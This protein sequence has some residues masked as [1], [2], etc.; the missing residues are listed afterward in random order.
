MDHQDSNNTSGTYEATMARKTTYRQPDRVHWERDAAFRDQP[1][2]QLHHQKGL[3]GIF[4]VRL[5]EAAGLERSYWSAL[6]IGPVKHLGLSTAHGPVSSYCTFGMDAE[7]HHN[8]PNE[9]QATT[10]SVEP[11]GKIP[12]N[13]SS[14]SSNNA[15][16]KMMDKALSHPVVVSPVMPQD[17]NPVWSDFHFELPLRKGSLRE[18]GMRIYLNVRVDENAHVAERILPGLPKGGDDRLIGKGRVDATSLCLGEK[19]LG[20]PQVGVLDAWVPIYYTANDHDERQHQTAA[21]AATVAA[22]ASKQDPL[23]K[24]SENN[25][26]NNAGPSRPSRKQV[27][28]VRVLISYRP[29]GMDPQ[30]ND[31]VALE[32]FARRSLRRSTC[33]PILPPLLPMIVKEIRDRYMLVEYQLPLDVSNNNNA[34]HHA[35]TNSNINQ[36]NNTNNKACM[37]LHRN[38]VFVIERKNLVDATVGFAMLPADVIMSTPLGQTGAQ[39]LGPV[40][41]AGKE[42]LM[43]AM[44]SFKL[45]FLALK[46]TGMAGLSGVQAASGAIWNEGASAWTNQ[47]EE[48]QYQR[49]QERARAQLAQL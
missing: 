32:S 14:N 20:Q 39:I 23:K 46:T 45:V 29:N 11:D 38:A 26:N 37:R 36:N 34:N 1:Y 5:L 24:P 49:E 3:M 13:P 30:Q 27:G 42:V 47:N 18:D 40:I 7:P 10:A 28:R 16:A 17:N 8:I 35:R 12:A 9:C 2:R 4:K 21:V 25:K 19:L 22:A 43:P 48:S 31:I 33:A 41:N 15:N 44:L 6:A